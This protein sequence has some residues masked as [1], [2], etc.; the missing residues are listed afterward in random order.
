M[1]LRTSDQRG[2][3]TGGGAKWQSFSIRSVLGDTLHDDD[4]S[5]E[6]L[7]VEVDAARPV[8]PRGVEEFSPTRSSS[9]AGSSE[10]S[11][12]VAAMGNYSVS[13]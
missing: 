13:N 9:G 10:N 5:E 7:D 1:L 4:D 11:G 6:D 12:D 2:P 3:Q 8:H